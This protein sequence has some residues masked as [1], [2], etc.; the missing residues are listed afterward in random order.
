MNIDESRIRA[1]VEEVLRTLSQAG[2]QA[3]APSPDNDGVFQD[4]DAAVDAAEKAQRE[5]MG[6]SLERRR[7][8]VAAIRKAGLDMAEESAR[9]ACEE[10]GMGNVPDKTQKH[11]IVSTL[12]PGVE[13][14][15]QKAWTGD[16]G[17]TVVEM[18][19]YG[20]IASVTPSTHP[21]P[22]ILNNAISILAAG[23]SV[24]FNPHPGARR[25][26]AFGLQ[27]INRGIVASGGPPNLLTMVESPT[28]ETANALFR[29]PGVALLLVTGGPGVVRAAMNA[30]KRAVVAGPGNPPAVVDETADLEKAARDII[31][32]ASF[33]NN[34][35]CIGEKETFVVA[36]V[37]DD[38]KRF[39]LRQGACELNAG[40]IEAL[41]GIAFKRD[42]KGELALNRELVGRD[43]PVLA[44]RIG[45]K[46]DRGV[47]LLIGETGFEHVF[48]QEEQ[49]MPFMP[50]V[51]VPDAA[52]AIDCA[53]RA[54]H[55]YRHTFVIHSR[56]VETMTILG[57]RCNA[58]LYV[59]NG[60][61]Y[62][63]L[64]V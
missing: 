10:T 61:S 59:K 56:N 7:E 55:G 57:K 36:S 16:H 48:V 39:M 5:L 1:I 51:R 58:C 42:S 19:P 63:G 32:G 37:A 13:D 26:S 12:T 34:I 29:H 24:V 20:V 50:I 62:A 8:I 44:E 22:T 54:E 23:N 45:L 35:L 9:R 43:A 3:G 41:A 31:A 11:V 27:R 38:L 46:I 28:I 30:P 18:A 60:P 21:V 47:R 4:V 40:Q 14:L 53:I 2:G 33:D 17:L 49:M 6:L 25:V 15:E 52:A 64:G